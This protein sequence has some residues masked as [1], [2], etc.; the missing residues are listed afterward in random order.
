MRTEPVAG[1]SPII[2][3]RGE[4]VALGPIKRELLPEYQRWIND[5]GTVRTLGFMP[6]PTTLEA[7]QQWYDQASVGDD[8]TFTIYELTSERPI[9][10]VSLRSIDFR[11]RTAS[12]G[13]MIGDP[14]ARGRGYGTE[15]TVLMLDYA[16]TA[17]GLH[18]LYLTCYEFNLAGQ[19]AYEKA[20]FKTIGRRR[21]CRWMGG[22]LWDELL[23]DCLATEFESPRLG[24]VFAPDLPRTS[25]R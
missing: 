15:A 5:F 6:Q 22:R 24:Q 23:M 9:G 13:L 14:D 4:L 8:K 17:L 10:V 18:S 1:E 2:Q 3:F 12:Y 11:N 20:G 25:D 19:R 7:E 21:Q 16:F